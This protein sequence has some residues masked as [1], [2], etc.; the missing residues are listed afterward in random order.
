MP[1]II[2]N[3]VEIVRIGVHPDTRDLSNA[4]R[5]LDTLARLGGYLVERKESRS[6]VN[7]MSLNTAQLRGLLDAQIAKLTPAQREWLRLEGPD[8][9]GLIPQA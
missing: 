1:W 2:S 4:N 8:G 6:E 5:A 3:L 9:V 7:L